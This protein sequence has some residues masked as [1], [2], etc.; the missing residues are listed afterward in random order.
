MEPGM[1]LLLAGAGLI[2]G[3][4]NAIAGGATL[5]TFPAM[6]AAG[7]PPMMANASNA[8]AVTPGHAL[9]GFADREKLPPLA[10]LFGWSLLTTLIGGVIG[11]ILLLVTPERVFSNL[12][13]VLIGG[14]TIIFGFAPQI[15]AL[16]AR[17]RIGQ[18]ASTGP[19]AIGVASIYGGYFGGGLG[20]ILMAVLGVT[21]TNDLRTNNAIKNIL[22]SVVSF[23]TMVIFI[24]Q[25]L[26][27]WT[28]TLIMLVG[29]VSGGFLGGRL[30]RILPAWAIR[31]VVIVAGAVLTL[32]Y[33]Y[34]T[35][36]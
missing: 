31:N 10:G 3:I 1:A 25:G 26:I 7:L 35:W 15:Q 34:R 18:G 36:F 24:A 12:V 6:M 2:G 20:V 16:A 21:T 30:I 9:A 5:I 19:V 14:A 29:T 22:A 27:G 8:V 23:A 28:E 32:V 4:A 17:F 11:G 13:P 33:A